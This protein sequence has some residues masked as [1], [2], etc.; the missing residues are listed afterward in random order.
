MSLYK[1]NYAHKYVTNTTTLTN[2]AHFRK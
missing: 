1:H 2:V